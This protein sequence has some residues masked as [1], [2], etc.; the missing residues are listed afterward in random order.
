M[1]SDL[2]SRE[3]IT[4]LGPMRPDQMGVTQTHEHLISMRWDIGP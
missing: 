1:S 4:V 2:N 3:V